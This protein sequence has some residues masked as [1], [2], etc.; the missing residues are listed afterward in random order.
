MESTIGGTRRHLNQLALGLPKDKF[1][2]TVIASA[3]RDAT[4]RSDLAAMARAGASVAEVPM[5]RN[6]RWKADRRHIQQIREILRSG[7][8]DIIH[9]HSSK[10]GALGRWASICE[11]QGRRVH[12][13]HTF[14]F[15]FAGGFS[16]GKRAVFYGIELLL[17]RFTHRLICVSPS[18]AQQAKKLKV[19]KSSR[20]AVIENGIDMEPFVN[21]PARAHARTQLGL[22]QSET[23]ALIVALLNSAKGQL[24]AVEAMSQIPRERRPLLICA[25]A[26]SDAEYGAAVERAIVKYQLQDRV[27]LAGHQ[28]NIPIW[29]AAANYVVCPSRWE[30]M[31]YA[32]LEAMAAGR[33]VLATATNGAKD[34]ILPNVTGKIVKIGD[35]AELAASIVEFTENADGC[36]RL[37]AAGREHVANH[38][39]SAKMI[40]NTSELYHEV[41]SQ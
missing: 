26:V 20:I 23:I 31:P 18:E 38:Y 12:T 3:E 13:P 11:K 6:I 9:T 19:I 40:Q 16:A 39:T 34:A 41:L 28:S 24:E 27:R 37:G 15:A 21:V 10:A 5:I 29:L 7:K 4:F 32:V 30:G 2:I 17:G 35:P 8:F 36:D 22:P 14:G 33:A 1:D 25:G